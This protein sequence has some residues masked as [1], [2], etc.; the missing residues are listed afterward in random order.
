VASEELERL[1]EALH[2]AQEDL[3]LQESFLA[4]VA[5]ELR[6]PIG[7][8][9]MS[10]DAM[11]IEATRGIERDVLIHRLLQM[12]RY[13]ERLQVDL[14]RLLDFSRARN[15]KIDLQLQDVDICD[16]IDR[17]VADV[18]PLFKAAGC[19]VNIALE[20]PQVGHWDAMRLRQVVWNLLTNATK[21]APSAP[22]DIVVTGDAREVTLVVRDH[23]AG[24]APDEREAVFRKFERAATARHYTGFGIGLWLVR[25]I[26]EALGGSVS[27]D[28]EVNVGTT[29]TIVLP[30]S[31]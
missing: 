7:P 3:K 18:E 4:V 16:V 8:V 30:R 24:I 29:F 17:V 6:N 26:V 10:V 1:R 20:R 28:T 21:Y 14:D 13:V 15:G 27:L 22:I 5:H 23:G 19:Q 11:L 25:R 2:L 12:R 31:R 9:L